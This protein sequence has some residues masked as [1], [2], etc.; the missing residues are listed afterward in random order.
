MSGAILDRSPVLVWFRRDL[1]L[2]DHPALNAA[3]TGDRP[4]IAVFI[5]DPE[6]RALGAAAQWRLGQGLEAF[7]RMLAARGS[8]LILRRGAALAVLRDLIAQTGAGAVFWTRAHDPATMARDHALK[9][10]LQGA[11]IEARS[12]P[13]HLLF[14]PWDVATA[15]GTPFRVF[16]PMWRAVR[17]REV[18]PPLPEPRRIPAPAHWPDSDPLD[19]WHLG[20]GV[21]RG[22]AV[23]ARHCR[24][25]AV[26]AQARLAGFVEQDLG[27]YA[28]NRDRP[29]RD[30]TSG[31]S[32]YLALGEIGVNRCWHAAMAA[33]DAGNKGAEP[34]LRQLVWREFAWHL[35][36]HFPTMATDNWRPEW[37][38]FP[39]RDDTD[40][41]AVRAWRQGRTGVALVD[42]G[43][44]QMY[45][46]GRMHNRARMVVASYLTKHLMTHWRIGLDWFA[47][48]LTD[49]D[50]ACN[51]LGWQWVAGSGP[52]AAPYFRIFN[53][54]TQAVKFD[55]SGDYRRRWL[56]EGQSRP[57]DSAASYFAAVPRHWRLDPK[58]ARPD[59]VVGLA[60]GRAAALAA[61]AGRP[62]GAPM[63][64]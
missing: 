57:P 61:W 37:D 53:P 18:A 26:A 25:G 14:E 49:W 32:E 46:S 38:G 29:D 44:R 12:H 19:S 55:P 7:A 50:P 63:T 1:R 39:W 58:A 10:A 42:A 4:V 54:D 6:T 64:R 30:A 51:A 20:A 35:L 15:Q 5:L 52:D 28:E 9:A 41:A 31:L 56:A 48:C 33:R 62:G 2:A 22:G 13:G 23:L 16:T 3:C 8:R 45:V 27:G 11:G 24:P 47:D 60:E 21:A 59:P 40:S 43:L 34:F 17:G 36:F